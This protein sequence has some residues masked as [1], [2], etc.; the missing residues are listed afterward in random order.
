MVGTVECLV[1]ADG[2]VV[3]VPPTRQEAL[4]VADVSKFPFDVQTCTVRYGSWVNN[5]EE[6]NFTIPKTPVSK[7]DY[8]PNGSW[9]LIS[10]NVTKNPGIYS[11]CPNN[12]YPSLSYAF[13]FRRHSGL[14]T[15]T[16]F[17][18]ALGNGRP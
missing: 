18:P 13:T 17:I 14:H 7:E 15:A 3:C 16:V 10:I 1:Y 9:D 2:T 11:C 5:G 12:T 4:C 6:I 8:E